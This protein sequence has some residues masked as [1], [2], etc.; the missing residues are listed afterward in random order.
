MMNNYANQSVYIFSN[1]ADFAFPAIAYTHQKYTSR[2]GCL[3]WLPSLSYWDQNTAYKTAY[4][5]Q[6]NEMNFFI[7]M[8]TDDIDQNKPDLIFVDMRN[9][10]S[11]HVKTYFGHTQ[12]DYIRFFSQNTAFQTTWKNYHYL[13]TVDGQPLFKFAIYARN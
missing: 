11:N 4:E 9:T 10:N 13:K 5:Q 7:H 8:T 12:I 6:K 2:V 1:S 3:G